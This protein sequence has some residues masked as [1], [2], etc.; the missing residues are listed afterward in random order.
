VGVSYSDHYAEKGLWQRLMDRLRS[1]AEH[2]HAF[3]PVIA[4]ALRL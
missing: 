4:L 3:S 1:V 2:N